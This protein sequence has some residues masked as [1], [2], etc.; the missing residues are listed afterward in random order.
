MWFWLVVHNKNVYKCNMQYINMKSL[1]NS[2]TFWKAVVVGITGILVVALT[3]LDLV[4]YITIVSAIS[5]VIL[6]MVTTEGVRV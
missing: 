3:E 1:Y 5:D 6:R 2:K 4:G